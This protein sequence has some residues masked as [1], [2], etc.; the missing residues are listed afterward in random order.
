MS[1]QRLNQPKCRTAL[2]VMI[3]LSLLVGNAYGQNKIDTLI[4]QMQLTASGYDTGPID[5]V[6]GDNIKT[7][8][9]RFQ[10]DHQLPQSGI[11]DPA[12]LEKLNTNDGFSEADMRQLRNSLEFNDA[13]YTIK[14][15]EVIKANVASIEQDEKHI[16]YNFSDRP[17]IGNQIT[18]E[19]KIHTAVLKTAETSTA[20]KAI[21][22]PGGIMNPELCILPAKTKAIHI[23][24]TKTAFEFNNIIAIRPQRNN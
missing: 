7:A 19:I 4:T 18:E 22:L 24:R 5:G 9:M 17:R 6:S 8:I 13:V 16:A 3:L 10:E 21:I 11:V 2:F 15:I 20:Q 1:S 12:T 23:Y 14:T